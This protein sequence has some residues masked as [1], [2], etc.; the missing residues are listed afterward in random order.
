MIYLVLIWILISLAAFFPV[1]LAAWRMRHWL[2]DGGVPFLLATLIGTA[3]Y[4]A[5]AAYI[6]IIGIGTVDDRPPSFNAIIFTI[7]HAVETV[8]M[9]LF[10]LWLLGVFHA[11]T[12]PSREAI[13]GSTAPKEDV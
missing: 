9:M 3:L 7:F 1:V 13:R 5:Y 11:D 8:P 4:N 6:G 2:R 10:T 12:P